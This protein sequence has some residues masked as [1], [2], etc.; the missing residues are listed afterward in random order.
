MTAVEIEVPY[1]AGRGARRALGLLAQ[2][3]GGELAIRNDG[4]ARSLRLSGATFA[5]MVSAA[6][7]GAK[8]VDL[9]GFIVEEELPRPG[10][11]SVKY[12]ALKLHVGPGDDG[13]PVEGE[14]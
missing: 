9:D 13:Q 7:R 4:R 1:E 11:G 3:Y 6:N 12:V 2:I 5:R 8:H 10:C 14:Q